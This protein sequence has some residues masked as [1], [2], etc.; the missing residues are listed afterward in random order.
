[1]GPADIGRNK[2]FKSRSPAG[3]SEHQGK[4]DQIGRDPKRKAREPIYKNDPSLRVRP[5]S[6]PQVEGRSWD[7]KQIDEIS[8][9]RQ[10]NEQARHAGRLTGKMQVGILDDRHGQKRKGNGE[11]SDVKLG[12]ETE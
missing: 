2:P 12:S 3:C 1:M 8:I 11:Q 4:S 9:D 7:Q 5:Q 10:S 6:P